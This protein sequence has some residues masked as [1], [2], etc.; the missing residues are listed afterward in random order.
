MLFRSSTL[1]QL[2]VG[3]TR[4]RDNVWLVT[5]NAAKLGA[6]I[7]KN[8]GN[9]TSALELIGHVKI[10]EKRE[11]GWQSVENWMLG[12]PDAFGGK[13]K[14]SPGDDTLNLAGLY[15]AFGISPPSNAHGARDDTGVAAP[16]RAPVPSKD[17]PAKIKELDR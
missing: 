1:R 5:D 4:A 16:I 6:R 10:D 15:E 9:K 14:A 17:E 8:L 3:L 2:I 13:S 11:D 7:E 12:D